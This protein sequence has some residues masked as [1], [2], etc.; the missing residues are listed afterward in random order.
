MPKNKHSRYEY[1][2]PTPTITTPHTVDQGLRPW[3]T[4]GCVEADRRLQSVP[5]STRKEKTDGISK[6][7]RPQVGIIP[8][9]QRTKKGQTPPP[10]VH[11]KRTSVPLRGWSTASAVRRFGTRPRRSP[12]SRHA[13]LNVS[14]GSRLRQK[15]EKT[16]TVT[17]HSKTRTRRGLWRPPTGIPSRW[18]RHQQR[19]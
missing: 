6:T 15:K 3:Q 4:I 10:L 5:K 19:L 17:A 18:R 2:A 9:K 1:P 16:Q 11:H 8:G 12:T 7:A 13:R 14:I